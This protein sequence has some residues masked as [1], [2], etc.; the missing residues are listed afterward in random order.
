MP[1]KPVK[2]QQ[3][4]DI[5]E[6]EEYPQNGS[7]SEEEVSVQKA[8]KKKPKANKQVKVSKHINQVN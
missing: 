1:K 2:Q 5:I 7:D 3:E 4:V 8:T 6:I